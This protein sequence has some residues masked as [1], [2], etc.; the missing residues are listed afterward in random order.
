MDA[1]EQ[2]ETLFLRFR[3]PTIVSMVQILANQR[4][5][6][7][8]TLLQNIPPVLQWEYCHPDNLLRSDG[9]PGIMLLPIKILEW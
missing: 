3:A 5:E 1:L 8:Q 6:E 2:Y 9:P 4:P 7:F